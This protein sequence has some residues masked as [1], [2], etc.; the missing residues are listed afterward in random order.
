MA[1][2]PAYHLAQV[3][4]GRLQAPLDSA[5]LKDFTEGLVPVNAVADR[6][7]GFVWRLQDE[8]GD[9]TDFRILGD[10]ELLINL[11]V[12]RDVD[13][14]NTFMYSGRHRELLKRRREFFHRLEEAVTALWWVPAG[15]LPSVEEAGERLLHLREHGPSAYAF[16]LRRSFP[17]PAE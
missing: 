10:P 4:V 6:S 17:P 14:L 16:S 3:N 12:W 13:A 1:D 7:D 9:A 8:S 2:S 15:H 5:Q 11:S